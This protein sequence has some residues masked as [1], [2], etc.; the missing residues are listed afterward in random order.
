MNRIININV[1]RTFGTDISSRASAALVR[2]EILSDLKKADH[3]ARAVFDFTDVRTVSGSFADELFAV[4]AEQY[5]DAWFRDHFG[6]VNVPEWIRESIVES[7]QERLNH[8]E[9]NASA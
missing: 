9:P 6:F 8:G 4:V 7:I 2:D 5:G 3:P 1:S